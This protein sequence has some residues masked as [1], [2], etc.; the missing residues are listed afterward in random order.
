[1]ERIELETI[2]KGVRQLWMEHELKY[3][4]RIGPPMGP[5]MHIGTNKTLLDPTP[6]I[7][8]SEVL[9]DGRCMFRDMHTIVKDQDNEKAWRLLRLRTM[10]NMVSYGLSKAKEILEDPNYKTLE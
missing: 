10:V 4:E 2:L 9:L 1:M 3:I 5:V 8:Y 7:M 6:D